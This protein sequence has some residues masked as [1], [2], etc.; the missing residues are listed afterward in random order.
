MSESE[1]FLMIAIVCVENITLRIAVLLSTRSS[2]LAV[3]WN[4]S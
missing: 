1:P 3:G 2:Q 4:D